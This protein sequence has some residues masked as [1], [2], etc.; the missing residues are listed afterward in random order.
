MSPETVEL[1]IP[2]VNEYQRTLY[3]PCVGHQE[4]RGAGVLR[5]YF[6]D[7]CIVA[8]FCNTQGNEYL[9]RVTLASWPSVLIVV[10]TVI[11]PYNLCD[12][13]LACSSAK[14]HHVDGYSTR[15]AHG[16]IC[17]GTLWSQHGPKALPELWMC[18]LGWM[19]GVC[20]CSLHR[21]VRWL[22]RIVS[23][24]TYRPYMVS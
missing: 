7:L 14:P 8:A 13:L 18:V 24:S 21:Q 17:P 22:E 11:P 15:T 6:C 20:R 10:K 12:A 5:S 1:A 9:K 23:Q 2:S 3:E 19:L 4:S 16:P